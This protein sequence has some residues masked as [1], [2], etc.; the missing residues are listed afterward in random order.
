MKSI[1]LLTLALAFLSAFFMLLPTPEA[2]T[3]KAITT[4]PLKQQQA[5]SAKS[6]QEIMTEQNNKIKVISHFTDKN[7]TP[8]FGTRFTFTSDE[9]MQGNSNAKINWVAEGCDDAGAL[10]VKATLGFKFAFPWSGAFY[11][12]GQHMSHTED[13]SN[14]AGIRFNVKGTPG[15]YRFMIFMPNL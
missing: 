4:E 10:K 5:L 11:M 14:Y 6:P 3:A 1:S 15:Q 13:L 7:L 12:L 9:M 2:T 8:Q